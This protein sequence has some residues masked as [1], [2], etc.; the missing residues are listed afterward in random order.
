MLQQV[1]TA[2]GIIEYNEVEVPKPK[3]GEVLLKMMTIGICGSDIHVNHGQHPFT[4]Y[5]ITQG[6][7]VSGEIAELGEGVDNFH[8]GQAVTLQ[9]QVV[10]GKCHPCRNGKYNLCEELKVLGFQTTGAGSHFFAIDA[11][12]VTPL[13]DGMTHDE[14]CM[15]EPLSV[16]VHA[17]R[18]AGEIENKGIEGMN[19]IVLGA[20]PIGNLI[21]QVAKGM[22]AAKVMITDISKFRLDKAAECGIDICINT[23]TADLGDA[24]A[25]HFGPDKADVIFDCAG[26]DITIDQAITCSRKGSTIVT[27]AVFADL[28]KVNMALANDK[29]LCMTNSMMF[30]NEDYIK[31]LELVA[32]KKVTLKPLV[33][34][35]F[36]FREFKEAYDY[37]D[38]NRETTMKVII[39]VQE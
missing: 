32:S 27:V 5:P 11:S 29:E 14:G 28:A 16:G 1:M 6:H 18:R 35:H 37:I 36:K 13:A 20:G 7:E 4:S 33:S 3:K 25:K 19:V 34:K 2:P 30:R 17:V 21:A 12:K 31:A 22:G 10:C 38:A 8:V 15:I 39:N 26:N 9:P 23:M 24:I